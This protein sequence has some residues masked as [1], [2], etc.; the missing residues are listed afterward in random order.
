MNITEVKL[1]PLQDSKTL[2]LASIT[3]NDEFV[4]TGLKVVQGNNGIFIAMPSRKS[5]SENSDKKY[6]DIAFPITKNAREEIQN[7]VISK[8]DESLAPHEIYESE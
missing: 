5:T 3:L 1:Y 2:A 4:I 8:Y 6:Y 7:A